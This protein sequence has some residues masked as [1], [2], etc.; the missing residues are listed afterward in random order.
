MVCRIADNPALERL[1][2]DIGA[3]RLCHSQRVDCIHRLPRAEEAGFY[4]IA[5]AFMGYCQALFALKDSH[6]R[7]TER[8]TALLEQENLPWARSHELFYGHKG[9]LPVGEFVADAAA[10]LRRF[11]RVPILISGLDPCADAEEVR[12]IF[13][14]PAEVIRGE[15]VL[16]RLVLGSESSFDALEA[17]FRALV[18]TATRERKMPRWWPLVQSGG[19]AAQWSALQ[20]RLGPLW[21]YLNV[22]V[23]PF[24]P[25]DQWDVL[26]DQIMVAQFVVPHSSDISSDGDVRITEGMNISGTARG[27]SYNIHEMIGLASQLKSWPTAIFLGPTLEGWSDEENARRV[28]MAVRIFTAEVARRWSEGG[29]GRYAELLKMAA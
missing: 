26:A 20:K 22:A 1:R 6:A 25:A 27:A 13:S 4:G 12:A 7:N 18:D 29:H 24:T 17:M 23:N 2:A 19:S 9:Q 28:A 5:G 14:S 15:T 16:V 8:V 3:D 21:R 11:G 10:P